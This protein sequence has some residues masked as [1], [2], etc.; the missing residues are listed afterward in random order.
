MTNESENHTTI[1]EAEFDWEYVVPFKKIAGGEDGRRIIAGY[2][3]NGS[4]DGD[5][6]VMDMDTLKAASTEYFKNP[7]VRF[8]HNQTDVIKGAI[9]KVIPEYVGSDGTVYKTEFGEKPFL[10]IEISKSPVVDP[11]WKMIEEGVYRG[12][13]IGGKAMKKVKVFSKEA[14]TAINKIFVK[15]WIETSIVDTPSAK[16]SF[17][18]VVKSQG[19]STT[20]YH[21]DD[22]VIKT[23]QSID[24]FILSSQLSSLDEFIKGGKGSGI[25]GHQSLKRVE[26]VRAKALKAA[27]KIEE[28]KDEPKKKKNKR[29]EHMESCGHV[30]REP[31]RIV[32]K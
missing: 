12:L 19:L 9:G 25:K 4:P 23:I 29:Q 8:M 28:E 5:D 31:T 27:K 30:K 3:S 32:K 26:S 1:L 2:A 15:S 11:I 13:S 6:E 14:G 24:S 17:F 7:V 18:N 16:G 21:N 20:S 10:V 22:I